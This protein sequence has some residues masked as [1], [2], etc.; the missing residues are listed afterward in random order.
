MF[1]KFVPA[2]SKSLG[3]IAPNVPV[4]EENSFVLFQKQLLG[5]KRYSIKI[6][7][8]QNLA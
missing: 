3:N 7:A 4:G 1:S 2:F 5:H 6:G 8:L